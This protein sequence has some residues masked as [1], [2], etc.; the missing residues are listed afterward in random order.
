MDN[1]YHGDYDKG[2]TW[3]EAREECLAKNATLITVK[4]RAEE[5]F[6]RNDLARGKVMSDKLFVVYSQYN[7]TV[8]L[9]QTGISFFIPNIM[10]RYGN[11]KQPYLYFLDL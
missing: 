8:R 2:V 9:R 1:C 4:T 7:A 6:V 11:V 10:L 5:A 3:H